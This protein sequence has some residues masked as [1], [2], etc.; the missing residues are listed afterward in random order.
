MRLVT[1]AKLDALAGRQTGTVNFG[2]TTAKRRSTERR[3]YHEKMDRHQRFN[4][5][6][7][8]RRSGD[9]GGQAVRDAHDPR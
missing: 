2:R 1:L 5:Q 8:Q 7:D 6:E 9:R 3:I 4:H